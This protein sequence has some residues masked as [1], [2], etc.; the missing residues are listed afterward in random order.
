MNNEKKLFTKK[1]LWALLLPLMVEQVLNS[2]MGTAD[3]I[4]VTSAGNAA[5]SA[6]SLVDSLNVMMILVFSALATGGAIICSQ[7]IGSRDLETANRAAGQLLLSVTSISLVVT[8]LCSVLRAPLLRLI[9][10]SVDAEVMENANIYMLITVLSFPFIALYNAG[11]ALFRASGNSRISM[12]ISLIANII[13]IGGNAILILGF[14]F[15]TAGAAIATLLSR[16][17]S[18]TLIL[19]FLRRPKQTLCIRKYTEIRPDFRMIGTICRVGI[20]TG[21]ENGMFQFGKLAI[22]STV[23]TL[24][25]AQI[26]ANAMMATL[27][28]FCC[29]AAIGIGLGLMTVVGQYIGA[30]YKEEAKKMILR[31]AR[32]SMVAITISCGLTLLL[33]RPLTKLSG[34]EAEA[35]A[36]TVQMAN[37]VCLLQPLF[38]APAF[39]LAYGMRAAGDVRFSMLLS[40][41]T[42]W[43]CRVVIVIVL[44]RVFGFGPIAVWIGMVSD[45]FIRAI[46]FTW[47][48]LSNRWMNKAVIKE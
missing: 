5:I 40:S 44:I 33:V 4:M 28:Q 17:F 45:W 9:F 22:Q 43:T 27:E 46:G 48:F 32:Y 15:G 23:S 42:M 36:L 6:V 34:M 11:A 14:H 10:G 7:Y 13:N 2:F 41:S 30:G 47:R 35:A 18:A 25:T 38:W 24:T 19:W 31:L 21:I 39:T 20:P 37:F 3:T 12:R 8:L 16:G 29:N 26:A 1:Q